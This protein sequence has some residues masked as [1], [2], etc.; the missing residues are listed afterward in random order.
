MTST[1]DLL[2]IVNQI[3]DLTPEDRQRLGKLLVHEYSSEACDTLDGLQ[4]G[5]ADLER[6]LGLA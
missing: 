6:E 1:A 2:K 3:A 4:A 5:F